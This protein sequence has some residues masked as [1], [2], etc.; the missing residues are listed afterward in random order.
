MI[1]APEPLFTIKELAALLK[2]HRSFVFAMKARGFQM[3]NNRATFGEAKKWLEENG[4]PR[5]RKYRRVE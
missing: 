3:V 5:L 2:R 1:Q 4:P